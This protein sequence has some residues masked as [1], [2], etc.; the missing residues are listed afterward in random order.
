MNLEYQLKRGLKPPKKTRKF[1]VVQIDAWIE[2]RARF[3]EKCRDY[4]G[5]LIYWQRLLNI[6]VGRRDHEQADVT[7]LA[8]IHYRMGLAHRILKDNRKSLHHLKYCVRLNSQEPRYFDAFGRASLA[9]GHWTVANEQFQRAL[10]LDPLNPTFL[11]RQAWVCL[12]ME[13]KESALRLVERAIVLRPKCRESLF[14]K[15]KI[16][17]EKNDFLKAI[18]TLKL[19][20]PDPRARKALAYCRE[21]LNLSFAG[22]TLS[23][24]K[25]GMTCEATP[26][27]LQDMRQVEKIWRQLCEEIPE[28]LLS[29]HLPNSWAAALAW[30]VLHCRA[31]VGREENDLTLDTLSHRFGATPNDIWPCLLRIQRALNDYSPRD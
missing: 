16:L 19:L 18:E 13:K 4:K 27:R 14:L 10:K 8:A 3:L 12:M 9:G 11:R 20:R 26:F 30:F 24:A 1:K 29:L 7:K 15:A 17:A 23:I 2:T 21:K 31:E 22:A 5:A 25:R 28:K 6:V